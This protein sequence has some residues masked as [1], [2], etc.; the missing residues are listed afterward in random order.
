M[1]IE[2]GDTVRVDFNGAQLTLCFRA[3][4]LHKPQATGES[5]Q[6]RNLDTG[7]IHYVSEG[8]TITKSAGEQTP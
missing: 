4:V 8:C 1:T 6:F 2:I 7:A 5:W 3:E